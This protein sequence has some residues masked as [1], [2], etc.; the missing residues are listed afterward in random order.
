MFGRHEGRF[1]PVFE[2]ETIHR[3][4]LKV[5]WDG[6]KISASYSTR[7]NQFY[8]KQIKGKKLFKLPRKRTWRERLSVMVPD[9]NNG[10]NVHDQ[11]QHTKV[12]MARDCKVIMPWHVFR[13]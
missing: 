8:T 11:H 12:N 6:R 13:W 3:V 5:K 4:L 7:L 9:E 2:D 10:G 1:Y